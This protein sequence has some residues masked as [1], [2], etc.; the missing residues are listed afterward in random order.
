V[1]IRHEAVPIGVFDEDGRVS[2]AGGAASAA[3]RSVRRCGGVLHEFLS[4]ACLFGSHPCLYITRVG[5]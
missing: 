1:C 5:V 3:T 4:V 2:E